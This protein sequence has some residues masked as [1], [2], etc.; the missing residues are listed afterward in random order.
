VKNKKERIQPGL[1][2]KKQINLLDFHIK[3]QVFITIWRKD[4]IEQT[5]KER[6]FQ[7][8]LPLSKIVF[9]KF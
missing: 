5:K 1:S 4:R 7:Y 9:I 8:A 3:K 2:L 6:T